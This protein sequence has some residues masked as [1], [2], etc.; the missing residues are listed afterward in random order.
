MAANVMSG[1]KGILNGLEGWEEGRKP[2]FAFS[3]FLVFIFA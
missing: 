3:L 2:D 1:F